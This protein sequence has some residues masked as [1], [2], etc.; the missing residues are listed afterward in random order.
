MLFFSLLFVANLPSPYALTTRLL[1]SGLEAELFLPLITS[2][3]EESTLPSPVLDG[4]KGAGTEPA[5]ANRQG[6]CPVLP[7]LL[8]AEVPVSRTIVHL[9]GRVQPHPLGT[10][11]CLRV[12]CESSDSLLDTQ[13]H[14]SGVCCGADLR[15]FSHG[16]EELFL[17]PGEAGVCSP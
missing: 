12:G 10:Q 2:T 8:Q 11:E 15:L 1:V 13:R 7:L 5:P 16:F 9:L 17:S 3:S 4:L 6:E 14:V